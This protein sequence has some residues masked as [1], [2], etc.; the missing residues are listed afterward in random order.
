MSTYQLLEQFLLLVTNHV[1]LILL[2]AQ[3]PTI[4]ACNFICRACTLAVYGIFLN[5]LS[6]NVYQLMNCFGCI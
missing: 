4:L 2:R 1:L 5:S 6:M 3:V